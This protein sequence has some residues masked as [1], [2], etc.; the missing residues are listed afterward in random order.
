MYNSD[1]LTDAKYK[2][3]ARYIKKT[4]Y[5]YLARSGRVRFQNSKKVQLTVKFFF[6]VFNIG[7][8]IKKRRTLC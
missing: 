3:K 7:Q 8:D 1:P 2:S 4:F 6:I 5:L